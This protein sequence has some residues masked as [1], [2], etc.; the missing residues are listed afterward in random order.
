VIHDGLI[1]HQVAQ[2]VIAIAQVI[3]LI[4]TRKK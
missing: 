3:V 4:A 2:L 1:L